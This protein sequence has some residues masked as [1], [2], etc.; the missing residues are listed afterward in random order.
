MR[1]GTEQYADIP[2]KSQNSAHDQEVRTDQY[3]TRRGGDIGTARYVAR[4]GRRYRTAPSGTEQYADKPPKS[5]LAFELRPQPKVR[6]S[7]YGTWRCGDNGTAPYRTVLCGT[8][9]YASVPLKCSRRSRPQEVNARYRPVR[10]PEAEK[11]TVPAG[12]LQYAHLHS[13]IICA[14]RALHLFGPFWSRAWYRA[15]DQIRSKNGTP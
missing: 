7:Q 10:A 11:A 9:H 12:N 13:G 4:R 8:E 3:G 6:T 5:N 14:G 2:S 1:S 15:L